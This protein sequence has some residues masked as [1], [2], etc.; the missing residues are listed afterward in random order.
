MTRRPERF[1][2]RIDGFF[3]PL[4]IVQRFDSHPGKIQEQSVGFGGVADSV[5]DT[6]IRY[7]LA[8]AH[9]FSEEQRRCHQFGIV[10]FGFKGKQIEYLSL[11]IDARCNFDELQTVL[12]QRENAPLGHIQNRAPFPAGTL[13]GKGDLTDGLDKLSVSSLLLDA[14]LAVFNPGFQSTGRECA[15]EDD[16]LAVLRDVDKTTT[17]RHTARESTGV[18]VTSTIALRETETRDI[19]PPAIYEIELRRMINRSNVVQ[20]RA[21]SITGERHT[22]VYAGIDGQHDLLCNLLLVGDIANTRTRDQR[23][24]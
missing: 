5:L 3:Y 22:T 1:K 16:L 13:A 20:G 17:P 19:D 18:D 14:Q 11:Y 12:A 23:Q 4:Q 7:S 8:Q 10:D 9:R 24:D 15:N 2:R 6:Y 21:E